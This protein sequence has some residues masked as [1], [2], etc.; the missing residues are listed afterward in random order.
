VDLRT[1]ELDLE[2]R[3]ARLTLVDAGG[4][5]EHVLDGEA[6]ARLEPAA[7]ALL[8]ALETRIGGACH[9]RLSS[10]AIDFAER[11]LLVD[12]EQRFE[13]AEYESL[14]RSGLTVGE[15]GRAAISILGRPRGDRSG[16]TSEPAFWSRVYSE[17]TQGFEL[18]RAAPP[19]RRW[20]EAHSPAG[21]RALVVGSGRGHEVRLLAS[22]G[23]HVVGVDFAPE[24]I[25]EARRICAGFPTEK[26]GTVEL[27]QRDLFALTGDPERYDLVVE[28][29][30]FCAIDPARRDEYVRVMHDL[31]VDGGQL[32][33]LFWAHGRQGGPPFSV[34]REEMEK[35]FSS[36]FV[37]EHVEVPSDSAALRAGH[38]LLVQLRKR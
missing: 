31:L 35:R 33:G 14:T 28:H 30:C 32:V 15:L 27:R 21:K 37:V 16:S 5:E 3:R 18:G 23:A 10:V 1:L 25:V 26:G 9:L 22:L 11:R 12:G 38:E 7:A 19:L 4:V 17:P 34:T 2:A 13:G 6:W 20:F 29:C 24:A 36:R 8:A